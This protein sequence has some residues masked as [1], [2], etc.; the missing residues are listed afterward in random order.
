M[1]PRR[2]SHIWRDHEASGALNALVNICSFIDEH[3][4]LTKSGDLGIV[5]RIEGI[6][7]E[8]LDFRDI[9]GFTRRFEAVLRSLTDEFRLYQYLLKR[10]NPVISGRDYGDNPV[11]NR[12]IQ[13]RMEFLR[14]KADSLYSVELYFVILY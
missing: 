12:A 3:T 2:V 14:G 13:S 5:L 10:T 7:Y 8:C 4:F 6:D 1:M 11:V 9:D